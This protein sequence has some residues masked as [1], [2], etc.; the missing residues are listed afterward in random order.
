MKTEI[1]MFGC[2]EQLQDCFLCVGSLTT[3]LVPTGIDLTW[4]DWFSIKIQYYLM[5][6]V[7]VIATLQSIP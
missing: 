6:M 7:V 2:G 5:S 1:V 3:P 4:I